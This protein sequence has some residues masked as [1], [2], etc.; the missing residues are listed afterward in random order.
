MR[1]I[2]VSKVTILQA[3]IIECNNKNS[4]NV[5]NNNNRSSRGRYIITMPIYLQLEG[6]VEILMVRTLFNTN[7]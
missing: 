1:S 6:G 5:G 3:T 7:D 2:G 4:I